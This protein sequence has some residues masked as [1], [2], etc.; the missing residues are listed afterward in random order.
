MCFN[1][2]ISISTKAKLL[3]Y[4]KNINSIKRGKCVHWELND[5]CVKHLLLF[6]KCCQIRITEAVESNNKEKPELLFLS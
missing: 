2:R 6:T 1:S 5:S 4:N 3:V